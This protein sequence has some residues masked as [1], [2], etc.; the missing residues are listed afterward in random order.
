MPRVPFLDLAREHAEIEEELKAAFAKVIKRGVFI[1]GEAVEAFESEWA[2]V[3]E[4]KGAVGV[5]NGTDAI[6]LSLLASGAIKKG[7]GDEVITGALTAPYTA[8]AI[9]NAGAVPVFADIDPQTYTIDPQ[10]IESVI[11]KRTRAIIPVHLYGQPADMEAIIQLAAQN[12]L[13][14][15][16]DAAQA[17]CA[18]MNDKPIGS[19]SNAATFSFYPTKNLGACGDGGAVISN[20]E[21]FLSRVRALRQGGHEAG[22]QS[23]I[24]GRNSRLDELQAEILLVKLKKL[25]EWNTR[26]VELAKKYNDALQRLSDFQ[27]PFI[28]EKAK[29]VFHL[30]V[31]RRAKRDALRAFLNEKGIETLIH[32][33]RPLHQETL[34]RSSTQKPLPVAERVVNEIISLPLYPQITDEEIERVIS[35][36][37]EF[38]LKN[39]C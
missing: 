35:A 12:N 20:D 5:A 36:I 9:L 19:L 27:T 22:L 17:H 13:I 33:P 6:T 29:H 4:S 16:E 34:F 10:S 26:R 2:G 30:Y 14:V 8:L 24:E 7:R 21:D 37:K 15:I 32:Y 39:P 23:Q 11:T 31:V 1:L 38:T 28:S 18:S 25:N 3:C